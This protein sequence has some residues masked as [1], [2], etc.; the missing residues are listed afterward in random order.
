MYNHLTL[1]I[2]NSVLTVLPVLM[3]LGGGAL[4]QS[5]ER[6]C[7]FVA[8]QTH[9]MNLATLYWSAATYPLESDISR[10]FWPSYASFDRT[11]ASMYAAIGQ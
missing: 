4:K 3:K 1:C 2:P 7:K 10:V 8:Y 9:G 6:T 5:I 11:R